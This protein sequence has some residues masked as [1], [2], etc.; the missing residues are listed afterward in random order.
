MAVTF[1]GL[2]AL[3][4][5]VMGVLNYTLLPKYYTTKKAEI[6]EHSWNMNNTDSQEN[7]ELNIKTLKFWISNNLSVLATDSNLKIVLSYSTD[8]EQMKSQLFTLS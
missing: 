4:I 2:I 1:I 6:L 5:V 7:M 8:S 3:S